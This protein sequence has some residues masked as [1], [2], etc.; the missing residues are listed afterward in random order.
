MTTLA[1]WLS[2]LATQDDAPFVEDAVTLKD[3]TYEFRLLKPEKIEEGKKYPLIL[4]LHGAG[5]RGAD[6]E[7]QLK[8]LPR[9]MAKPENRAAFPSFL[10]APQC[11]PNQWWGSART[12][13]RKPTTL[14]VPLGDQSQA[15]VGALLKTLREQ[16]VDPDRIYL[17]GLSMGGYGSWDLAERHPDWFAAVGPICGGGDVRGADRLVG[18]PLWAFHGDKDNAVP[19]ARSREMI[20]AI[21]ELGG[22]PKYTELAG[23]GHDSWTHAYTT[24][25]LV[26]WLFEQRRDPELQ[27]PGLTVLTGS[28]S[29]LRKGDR[30]VFLG[31]SITQAGA[32]PGGYVTLL[33]EAI[34]PD[35]G[36]EI[37]G[38]GISGN[39]V[40]DL[41]A[42]LD[43]DVID[44]KPTAVFVFIGVNDVWHSQ[45]GKG[46]PKDAY[47]AGLRDVVGRIQKAGAIVVL[48]TPA[49]IGEKTDGSNAL[50]PMLDDYCAISRMVAAE[51]GATLCDLRSEFLGHL[52]LF[53]LAGAEKNVLTTDGVHLSAAGNR[54]VARHAALSL[55][56]ALRKRT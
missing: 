56:Q 32:G 53:N 12:D 21:R 1:L 38:A 23:V 54:F 6:N 45:R 27:K 13:F 25:G 33:R 36:V 30:I 34:G 49:A 46:T 16:P 7:L 52:T 42:R 2:V 39:R 14:D 28:A 44:R 37:V 3:E 55:A 22:Q 47:E 26:P 11:R 15:A 31:D 9:I 18:L 20:E 17:T 10:L 51:T 35:R 8:F 29:P 4:F 19:V 41:Q 24:G 48:A 50:D 43:K 5:E 40:P